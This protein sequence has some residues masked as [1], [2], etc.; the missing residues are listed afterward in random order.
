MKKIQLFLL[1]AVLAMGMSAC[2][3]DEGPLISFVPKTERIANTW[4]VNEANING[5][6]KSSIDG[7]KEITFFKEGNCQIVYTILSTDVAYGGTWTLSDD[8]SYIRI[9]T[10]DDLTHLFSYANDWTILHLKEDALKVSY[11]E[12]NVS[13]GTDSYVVTFEPAI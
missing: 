8:K 5:T 12:S 2:K 6:S 7:F 4:V 1:L 9:N 13:G 3:Y 11:S 10:T